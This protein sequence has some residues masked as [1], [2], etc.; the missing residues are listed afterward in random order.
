MSKKKPP[1]A[2]KKANPA[3][4]PEPK[5]DQTTPL[6]PPSQSIESDAPAIAR[7]SLEADNE[8]MGGD[9]ERLDE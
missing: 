6:V 7:R 1:K 5:V 2:A 9:V 4:P 3:P 8:N